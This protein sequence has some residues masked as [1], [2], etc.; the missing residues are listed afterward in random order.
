MQGLPRQARARQFRLQLCA[1]A[2]QQSEQNGMRALLGGTKM[3]LR[4]QWW[5]QEAFAPRLKLLGEVK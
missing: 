4:G 5:A 1:K 2:V 3:I